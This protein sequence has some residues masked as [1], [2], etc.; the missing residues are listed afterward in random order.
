MEIIGACHETMLADDHMHADELDL[1]E[2]IR[3]EL[4]AS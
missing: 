4:S 1:P 3:T 2:Q